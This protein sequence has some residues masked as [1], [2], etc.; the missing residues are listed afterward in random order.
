MKKL[1]TDFSPAS[2]SGIEAA[3]N[4]YPE[5]R[6]WKDALDTAESK[7]EFGLDAGSHLKDGEC[8]V[9]FWNCVMDGYFGLIDAMNELCPNSIDRR[10]FAESILEI[11][12][13][14]HPRRQMPL[15]EERAVN[16][17]VAY[18]S[19]FRLGSIGSKDTPM[20]AALQVA[21]LMEGLSLDTGPEAIRK[22]I[23]R[24]RDSLGEEEVFRLNR[25]T[26]KLE[27]FQAKSV[28]LKGLPNRRGRPRSRKFR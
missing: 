7:F 10:A 19:G 21:S 9:N 6:K 24:F 11:W 13:R 4:Q 23:Q 17:A 16:V 18:E 15:G 27:V 1:K 26:L 14:C 8:H 12:D 28:L 3:C 25:E 2:D 22:S 5:I 20:Q